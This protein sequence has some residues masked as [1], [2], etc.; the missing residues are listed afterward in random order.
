MIRIQPTQLSELL[1]KLDRGESFSFSRYWDGEMACIV[2][3]TG[4]NVDSC[5]YT[6]ELRTALISTL[7]NNKPY[8]HAIFFP[9]WH[10][11]TVHLRRQFEEGLL[12]SK[13]KVIWHDATMF[14]KAFELGSFYPVIKS[15]KKRNCVLIGGEHLRPVTDLLGLKAFVETPRKNA[16]EKHVEIEQRIC[17]LATGLEQPV[18]IFCTGMASNCMI[19]D[20]Y[21]TI[22]ATMIDMGSVWDAALKLRTRIWMRSIPDNVVRRNLYGT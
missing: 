1:Q 19:D 15:L 2:G 10:R 9:T 3:R 16:Y 13:C 18:F 12:V 4:K 7:V 11:G 8:Y 20:L 6:P 14:Q 5:D 21:G 17:E 22:D